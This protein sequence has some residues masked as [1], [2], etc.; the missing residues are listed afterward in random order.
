LQLLIEHG[1]R[2]RDLLYTR[3][4]RLEVG[5]SDPNLDLELELRNIICGYINGASFQCFPSPF[6]L[7]NVAVY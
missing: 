6:L 5:L 7:L 1:I 4:L 2:T 3:R